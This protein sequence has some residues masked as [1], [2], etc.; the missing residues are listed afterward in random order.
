MADTDAVAA[1]GVAVP[2]VAAVAA[3][4]AAFLRF[5]RACHPRTQPDEDCRWTV[6]PAA[7]AA[8]CYTGHSTVGTGGA[9]PG[10]V[11]HR[12]AIHAHTAYAQCRNG[13]RA[14]RETE[15][16]T[17]FTHATAEQQFVDE[18][19]HSH[20]CQSARRAEGRRTFCYLLY[21]RQAASSCPKARNKTGS[22]KSAR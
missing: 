6:R 19:G 11:G 5:C 18:P 8:R 3:T 2:A 4:R 14:E 20:E 1:F 12:G 13:R 9:S 16:P 17:E 21:G 7:V 15:K 10:T 22:K